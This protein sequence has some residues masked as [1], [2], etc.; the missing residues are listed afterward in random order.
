MTSPLSEEARAEL[1]AKA[2]AADAPNLSMSAWREARGAFE[3]AANP[4]TILS[5]EAT[6]Q[7]LEHEMRDVA[8]EASRYREALKMI[9]IRAPAQKPEVHEDLDNRGDIADQ[10]TALEA[11][12][13]S[14][15]ASAAL[16]APPQ[17]G[18]ERD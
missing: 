15:I 14:Q 8:T 2:K 10:A 5:Y 4:S 1:V 9:A 7:A 17:G 12:E 3:V 18:S 16:Q 11:W 13:C 6:V